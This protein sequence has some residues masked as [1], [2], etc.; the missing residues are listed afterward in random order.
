MMIRFLV[1]AA[2]EKAFISIGCDKRSIRIPNIR[3]TSCFLD[4]LLF[5]FLPKLKIGNASIRI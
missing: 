5:Y 4:I 3:I 1:K 2:L